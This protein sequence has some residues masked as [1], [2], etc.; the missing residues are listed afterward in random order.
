M[1]QRPNVLVIM[2]DGWRRQALGCMDQDP[3]QTP[4]MDA[5]AAQSCVMESAYSNYPLCTPARASFLT[6]KYAVEI[7]ME[8]NWQRLP[9]DEPSISQVAFDHGYDT[10]L[11]GKWHLDDYE[12]DD[13]H[14]DHWCTF[15]PPGERRMGFRYWYCNGCCH[16]HWRLRYNDTDGNLFE[17]EGWQL[18]HE[19]DKALAYIKNENDERPKEKPWFLCLNWSPPHNEC[20][21]KVDKSLRD[22]KQYYAPEEFEKPYHDRELAMHNPDTDADAYQRWAPG[23]FGAITSMDDEFERIYSYLKQQGLD[24]N[25][26]I[27]LTA[28]HGEMLGTHGRWMKDIWYEESAGIPFIIGWPE[29]IPASRNKS[30]FSLVDAAPSLLGLMNLPIPAQRSGMDQSGIIKGLVAPSEKE[31]LLSHNTGAPPPERTRYEFPIEKGMYWRGLRSRRYT[32]VIVDQREDSIFYGKNSWDAFPS[33]ARCALFDNQEDP[34]QQQ[35]IY[36][37]DSTAT[38]EVIVAI[39]KKLEQRLNEVNDDF[40]EKY[41]HKE[42][43]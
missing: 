24:K 43:V 12:E 6:G 20:G 9:V 41:W 14:G 30:L 35:A 28:D 40:I 21:R 11:I 42:L 26:I 4:S 1:E 37:G 33:D 38:D 23:Y 25:T 16:D 2:A 10:A 8:Y 36:L 32:Y 3:V 5:F 17:G 13:E 7:G 29:H 27:V 15:S 34:H 22:K 31:V 39:H 18:T 19:T